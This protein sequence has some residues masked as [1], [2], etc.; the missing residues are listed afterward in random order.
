MEREVSNIRSI[1]AEFEIYDNM[2]EKLLENGY[3]YPTIEASH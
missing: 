2:M 1:G 3:R